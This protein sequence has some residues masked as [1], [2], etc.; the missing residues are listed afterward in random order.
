MDK[1]IKISTY[2][3]LVLSLIGFIDALYLT[4]KKFLGS[5]LNCIVG[6]G[7][8]TAANSSYA[9]IF[10]IPLSLFGV[11]FYLAVFFLSIRYLE[12]RNP[13][14]FKIIF[15]LVSLGF[16]FALYLLAIQAFFVR[17]FCF[18]CLI[19]AAVSL[20]LFVIILIARGRE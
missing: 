7:C 4:V 11:F 8:I 9:N 3:V 16:V 20:C 12:T 13:K 6:E 1:K 5:P 17:A 2:L 15:Y 19:S 10:G 18:Y 14:N